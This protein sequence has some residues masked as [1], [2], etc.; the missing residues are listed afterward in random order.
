MASLPPMRA[1]TRDAHSTTSSARARS[2]DGIVIPI[3][4]GVFILMTI[5]LGRLLNGE[6]A[7][8]FAIKNA[9]DI[10]ADRP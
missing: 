4:F 2:D 5:K 1:L 7:R 8:L 6:V 10:V 9:A 3:A